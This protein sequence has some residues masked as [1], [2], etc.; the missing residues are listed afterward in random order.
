MINNTH[1]HVPKDTYKHMYM[2]MC[3]TILSITNTHNIINTCTCI[4]TQYHPFNLD[5]HTH[6]L[7]HILI[8][9]YMY[10]TNHTVT[11]NAGRLELG[12]ERNEFQGK[13]MDAMY[14]KLTLSA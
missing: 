5:V 11:V 4:Q 1:V 13:C 6:S 8:H 10:I 3:I 7:T 2:Y 9:V 12:M 14:K